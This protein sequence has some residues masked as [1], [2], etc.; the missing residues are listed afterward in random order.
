MCNM[1]RFRV[2][3]EGQATFCTL[4]PGFR[5]RFHIISK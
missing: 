1:H 3:N 4:L 2:C 5:L